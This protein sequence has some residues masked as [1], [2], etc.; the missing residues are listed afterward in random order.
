MNINTIV[1]DILRSLFSHPVT[2]LYPVE[3]S[4][5]SPN[6]RG[7][8]HY[9]PEGCTGCRL[10]LLDCPSNA[11]E[12]ITI[13]KAEKRFAMIYHE[14][15]CA[16]CGQCVEDCRFDCL[17][18]VSSEWELA[19]ADKERFTYTYGQPSGIESSVGQTAQPLAEQ[20]K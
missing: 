12:L 20:V 19:D 3:R 15:R 13:S 2:Q 5:P 1:P 8:L 9:V 4:E 10:C 11:L 18:L 17:Q 14:D 6:L 16:F 7:R